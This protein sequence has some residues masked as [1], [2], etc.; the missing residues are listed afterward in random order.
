MIYKFID[1]NGSEISVNSLSSL[2]ALVDSE[3]VKEDTKV[4]AGLRGKWTVASNIE[5]LVFPQ[6]TIDEPEDTITPTED[7]KSFIVADEKNSEISSEENKQ[8]EPPLPWQTK[9]EENTEEIV[10]ETKELSSQPWQTEDNL[11]DN[12][13]EDLEEDENFDDTIENEVEEEVNQESFEKQ[14]PKNINF[15]DAIK[16]CFNKYFVID[17]RASRSEYWWFFLFNVLFDILCELLDSSMGF[18]YEEYG[19][20]FFVSLI[21]VIPM[22]TVTARRLHDVDKSGWWMLISF[23]IIGIIPLFIWTISKG[24]ESKNRFGEYP[25]DLSN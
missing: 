24:E 17:G 9:K 11:K 15:F 5:E 6:E 3:T 21:T 14:K 13:G 1:N 10:S 12:T 23:T 22:I 18:E 25:L 20:F 8:E 19:M 4:K 2:Q 7:I 16:I